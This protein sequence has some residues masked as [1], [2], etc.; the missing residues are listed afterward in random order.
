MGKPE[1]H[2]V[3]DPSGLKVRHRGVFD[4]NN[5]YNSLAYYLSDY[6]LCKDLGSLEKRYAEKMNGPVKN[7]EFEW[8]TSKKPEGSTYFKYVI[9][10]KFLILG[11]SDIE[12]QKGDRKVKANKG[13]FEVKITAYVESGGEEFDK[14]GFLGQIY[15]NYV[16]RKRLDEYKIDLY[17]KVYKLQDFVKRLL[18][19]YRY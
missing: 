13:D 14:L 17:S 10:M 2:Y 1:I 15:A 3:T 7:L 8:E 19:V 12:I 9:K 18:G 11:L 5:I 6:G 16:I 4:L